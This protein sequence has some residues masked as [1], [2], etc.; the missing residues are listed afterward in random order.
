MVEIGR[1]VDFTDDFKFLRV[2]EDK[3]TKK[4]TI[5]VVTIGEK[6]EKDL[7]KL[8]MPRKL[9]NPVSVHLLGYWLTGGLD[10][11]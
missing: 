11:G 10:A 2:L 9:S 1:P 3:A 5:K 6:P 4:Q 8:L 7:I